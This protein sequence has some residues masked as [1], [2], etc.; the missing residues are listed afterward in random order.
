MH[1]FNFFLII[2]TEFHSI[3]LFSYF[4]YVTYI[5]SITFKQYIYSSPF[6]EVSLHLLIACKL[7]GKSCQ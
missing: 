7:G 2:L 4:L 1:R 6:A 3:C 5:H